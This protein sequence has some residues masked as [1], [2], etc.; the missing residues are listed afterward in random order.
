[1]SFEY[2]LWFPVL[3]FYRISMYANVSVSKSIYVSYTFALAQFLLVLRLLYLIL[4]YWFSFY[5]TSFYYYC[6]DACVYSNDKCGH[7]FGHGWKDLEAV[8]GAEIITS[9]SLVEK[10]SKS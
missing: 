10:R 4:V 1:M 9:I 3:C 2:M 7:P 5:L 6:F 8:E